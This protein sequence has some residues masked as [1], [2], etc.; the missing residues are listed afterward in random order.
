MRADFADLPEGAEAQRLEEKIH[1]DPDQLRSACD[2]LTD[3]LGEMY[4][5]LADS[6]LR[7]EQPQKAML[8]LE[9]VVQACPG[10]PQAETVRGRLAQL[11]KSR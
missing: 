3:R 8:C 11:N 10:T 2:N 1:A 7:K 6:F 4:L 9:W 5:D